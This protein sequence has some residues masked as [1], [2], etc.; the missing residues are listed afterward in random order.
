[1]EKTKELT[2]K[3]KLEQAKANVKELE[4]QMKMEAAKDVVAAVTKA[5]TDD[6]HV[7]EVLADYTAEEGK[8]IGKRIVTNFD[9]L[10]EKSQDE[11]KALRAKKAEREARRKERQAHKKS[12]QSIADSERRAAPQTEPKPEQRPAMPVQRPAQPQGQNVQRPVQEYGNPGQTGAPQ[13]Q[14]SSGIR[15]TPGT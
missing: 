10:V 8:I 12:E 14:P 15:Y 6:E 4:R 11:I 1:M 3:E 7:S 2:L 9:R 13:T 5:I